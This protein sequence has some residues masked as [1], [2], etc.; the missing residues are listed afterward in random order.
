MKVNIQSNIYEEV[1][2]DIFLKSMA[3]KTWK[4]G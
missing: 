2:R 4:Y 3:G 1:M